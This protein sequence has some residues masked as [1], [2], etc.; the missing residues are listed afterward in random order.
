MA[1]TIGKRTIRREDGV[2]LLIA[3]TEDGLAGMAVGLTGFEAAAAPPP[4]LAWA[5]ACFEA[6][7][8]LA[9]AAGPKK[10][11]PATTATARRNPRPIPIR[12][13]ASF[14]QVYLQ[15]HAT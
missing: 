14:K 9:G 10:L 4:E 8:V 13:L 7:A 12:L 3:S 15:H 5:R 11:A 6:V 1:M 2:E